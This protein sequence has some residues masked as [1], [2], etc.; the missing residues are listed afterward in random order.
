[1]KRTNRIL[2]ILIFAFLY[3]PM[4]VLNREYPVNDHIGCVRSD[5][6]GWFLSET[7]RFLNMDC[8]NI[9]LLNKGVY[10]DSGRELSETLSAASEKVQ[11]AGGKLEC[12]T[13]NDDGSLSIPLPELLK[14]HQFDALIVNGS[15]AGAYISSGLRALGKVPGRDIMIS[16]FFR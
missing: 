15:Q 9:L 7:E 2:T 3:L 8:R 13:M 6:S 1:M 12:M 4:V 14:A 16:G 10:A 11:A 5:L